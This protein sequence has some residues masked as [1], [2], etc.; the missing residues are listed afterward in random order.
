MPVG[1]RRSSASPER[2]KRL[3][4]YGTTFRVHRA[5]FEAAR[6]AHQAGRALDVV[7]A[8]FAATCALVL[9]SGICCVHAIRGI[10]ARIE[11]PRKD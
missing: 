11:P 8:D 9:L 10:A 3:F 4:R 6:E 2:D 1:S 7:A 5:T